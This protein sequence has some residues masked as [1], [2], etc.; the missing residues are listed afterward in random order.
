MVSGQNRYGN[1]IQNSKQIV[2]LSQKQSV[3]STS[4][5]S[6]LSNRVGRSEMLDANKLNILLKSIDKTWVLPRQGAKEP[7]GSN[8]QFKKTCASIYKARHGACKQMGFGIMCFNYCYE[9]GEILSF[10]CQDASD[11]VYC[12]NNG[13]FDQI[14]SKIRKD[15]YKA[16][17]FVHQTISRCYATAICSSQGLLNSTLIDNENNV[18]PNVNVIVKNINSTKETNSIE[19]F[20]NKFM[21][22]FVRS[23][24]NGKNDTEEINN[25]GTTSKPNIWDRFTVNS[26]VKTTPKHVPFWQKLML[27]STNK[28]NIDD[29]EDEVIGTDKS[30][31]LQGSTIKEEPQKNITQ[32]SSNEIENKEESEEESNEDETTVSTS[33]TTTTIKPKTKKKKTK[34]NKASMM[35]QQTQHLQSSTISSSEE[36]IEKISDLTSTT[37][38]TAPTE[39]SSKDINNLSKIIEANPTDN[40]NIPNINGFWTKFQPG[41]WYQSVHYMTNTGKK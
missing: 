15:A 22:K 6:T 20:N 31:E 17:S 13:N 14:L 32:K 28:P 25:S 36:T 4:S 21:N 23:K 35:H 41:K 16:K 27:T 11:S 18:Q 38:N 24:P 19:S 3:I 37:L 1:S 10:P 2:P 12:K 26:K 40:E 34:K 8:F 9:Q 7:I 39:S 29:N 5:Q 30:G 33:T